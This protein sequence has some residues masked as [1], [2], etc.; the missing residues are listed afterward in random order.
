MLCVVYKSLKKDQTYLY[1]E[2]RDDFSKVPDALL[3]SFGKP[4]LVTL[5]NLEKRTSLALA[6]LSKVK[7]ELSDKG[8]YLQLPPPPEDLLAE[9]KATLQLK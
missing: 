1:I 9:H 3:V 5:I 4:Q 7:A 6:D 2:R 8:Y